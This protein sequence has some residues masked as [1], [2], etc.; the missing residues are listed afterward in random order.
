MSGH[1]RAYGRIFVLMLAS[2]LLDS[3]RRQIHPEGSA[4]TSQTTRQPSVLDTVSDDEFFRG[5][6]FHDFTEELSKDPL[7][8]KVEIGGAKSWD[9]AKW[10]DYPLLVG[11]KVKQSEID[12]FHPYTHGHVLV[13]NRESGELFVAKAWE[14]KKMPL[15]R[16]RKDPESPEEPAEIDTRTLTSLDWVRLPG[17]LGQVPPSK[18][19]IRFL[20][21]SD[22]AGP[23]VVSTGT[24]GLRWQEQ[25]SWHASR[26]VPTATDLADPRFEPRPGQARLGGPGVRLLAEPKV[27]LWNGQ[28]VRW[29]VSGGICLG[30]S[31]VA[32]DVE[33]ID[34][35][36]V[37]AWKGSRYVRQHDLRIPKRKFLKE[38]GRFHADF[39]LD[40][41]PVFEERVGEVPRI[42][43]DLH[44]TVVCAS[45]FFGPHPLDLSPFAASGR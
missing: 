38:N 16:S 44:V 32:W 35:H 24:P 12:V 33:W 34:V 19:E 30:E 18:L 3:C 14:P 40:L 21:G 29:G 1:V 4:M 41:Y 17:K 37:F 42:P 25:P 7:S 31:T 39:F 28:S 20:T 43:R 5:R 15:A 9:P 23:V 22:L 8:T 26:S 36:L 45:Q 11:M 6:D 10:P 13:L 27:S 2:F